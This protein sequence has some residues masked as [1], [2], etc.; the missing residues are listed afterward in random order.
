[1]A[2]GDLATFQERALP[3][4]IEAAGSGGRSDSVSEGSFDES[5]LGASS[6]R[7]TQTVSIFDQRIRPAAAALRTNSLPQRMRGLDAL[8]ETAAYVADVDP[9]VADDIAEYLVSAR[10]PSEHRQRL[11]RVGM[12]REWTALRIALA[13]EIGGLGTYDAKIEE[14][15]N[16]LLGRP[17]DLPADATWPARVRVRLLTEAL[18][19][20]ADEPA[21]TRRVPVDI[22]QERLRSEWRAQAV[23][24][25]ADEKQTGVDARVPGLLQARIT[26]YASALRARIK[27]GS[28]A[29]QLADVP[30]QVTAIEYL[31][32]NELE[33][34]VLLDRIW[35][36]LLAVDHDQALGGDAGMQLV[37]KLAE[38]DAGGG[39]LLQQLCQGQACGLRLWLL[40][41]E[42]EN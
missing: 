4:S 2:R 20:L 26:A 27:E 39:G 34:V 22:L 10:H 29:Q 25:E 6:E 38:L 24:A 5:E 37:E 7:G 12:L 16:G 41:L 13:H 42:K 1:L 8:A 17:L 33:R 21:S 23:L 15:L 9:Q 36:W 18:A 32:K 40:H 19:S 31:A 35:V 30:H 11:E 14:T 3:K 28:V